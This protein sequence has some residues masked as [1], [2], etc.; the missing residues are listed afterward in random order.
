ML[1]AHG[2][3]VEEITPT[4]GG[5]NTVP[6]AAQTAS[7]SKAEIVPLVDTFP[8]AEAV[9]ASSVTAI[10]PVTVVDELWNKRSSILGP[11]CR[12]FY[13]IHS[14]GCVV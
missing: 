6:V 3:S 11:A 1:L 9:Q 12:D 13:L 4:A 5:V 7:P 8:L 14:N 10:V 2:L